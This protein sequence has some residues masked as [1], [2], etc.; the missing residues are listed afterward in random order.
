[1]EYLYLSDNSQFSINFES[2]VNYSLFGLLELGLSSLSL[3]EFP[4]FSE[5]LPM[6][7]YLDLSNNKISGSVPNWLHEVYF[8]TNL[9]HLDLSYNL[10]TG[11]ISLS[12][13]NASRLLFL[14]LAYNQ[15]TDTIPQCLANL[16][17]LEVLDLQ[18]NKFHGPL[19]SNFSKESALETLNLY[20]N[21][22]EDHI[23]KSLSLCKGLMFLNL[24]RNK[25]EDNFPHWLQTLQYLK[26]FFCET[27]SY[28]VSLLI[29]RSSI[30]FQI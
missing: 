2:S 1:M 18:M 10:L 9:E 4:N 20:G 26:V 3:T 28:T 17:S 16:S 27:I 13:W 8:W 11:N 23:P 25:I 5:K 6:L 19:P 22:L 12:I 15:L 30:H 24:G 7:R 14:N 21:Q 29:Q